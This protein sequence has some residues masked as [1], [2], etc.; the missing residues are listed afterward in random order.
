[1]KIT[2][3]VMCALILGGKD[4]TPHA[5]TKRGW[6]ALGLEVEV[7]GDYGMRCLDKGRKRL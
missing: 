4:V 2:R 1:M 5:V 7:F 6:N 3:V